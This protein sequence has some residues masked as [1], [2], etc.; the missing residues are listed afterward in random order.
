ML[1]GNQGSL[2]YGDDSVM[3]YKKLFTGQSFVGATDVSQEGT[4][5]WTNGVLV[6][7]GWLYGEPNYLGI[8]NCVVIIEE[9]L[10][11]IECELSRAFICEK[12]GK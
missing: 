4:F 11:N 3:D 6:T 8:E 12:R 1:G 2:L 9:G 7:G 10:N 5:V